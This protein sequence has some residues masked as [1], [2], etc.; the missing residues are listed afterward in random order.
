MYMTT[1][2]ERKTGAFYLIKEIMMERDG[3]TVLINI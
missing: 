3:A 1:T 2:L